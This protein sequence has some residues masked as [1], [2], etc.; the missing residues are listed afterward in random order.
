MEAFWAKITLPTGRGRRR[1]ARC[2]LAASTRAATA[3]PAGMLKRTHA[4]LPHK[5]VVKLDFYGYNEAAN[6]YL[7]MSGAFTMNEFYAIF[8][9]E[10]DG[11]FS[12]SVPALPG[13]FSQGDTFEE[14]MKNIE[15]AIALYLETM[16]EL[17]SDWEPDVQPIFTVPVRSPIH[18]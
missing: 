7:A 2:R 11:G 4:I 17:D 9:Q 12:V 13:C 16:Q 10:E 1:Q 3:A 14:A 5:P 18:A 6:G 15:E 8:E